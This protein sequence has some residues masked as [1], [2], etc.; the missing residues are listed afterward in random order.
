MSPML[1]SST[2]LGLFKTIV[3]NFEWFGRWLMAAGN[4]VSEVIVPALNR[5]DRCERNRQPAVRIRSA[6]FAPDAMETAVPAGYAATTAGGILS[7]RASECC[8]GGSNSVSARL[9]HGKGA[10]GDAAAAAICVL[11]GDAGS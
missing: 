6:A 11:C 3:L 7:C 10:G 9:V 2:N 8:A 1:S 5:P 4:G